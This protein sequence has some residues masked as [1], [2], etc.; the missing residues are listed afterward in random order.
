MD[1]S[2]ISPPS[3]SLTASLSYDP[4]SHTLT[5]VSSGGPVNAVTWTRNGADIS[6]SPYQLRQSLEDG[7]TSTYHNLLT[8]TNGDVEDYIGSFSCTVS[9]SRGISPPQTV[10]VNG[11]FSITITHLSSYNYVTGT[12]I[13][14]NEE[15]HQ[16]NSSVT[17]TCSS[18]LAVQ[19]IQW[20]N[21][22]DNQQVLISN[23]GQQPLLLPIESAT[24][25][26]NNTT[27]TCEVQ[28]LLATGVETVQ[29][30]TTFRVNSNCY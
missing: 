6:S 18:D 29:E 20:L 7:T 26:L 25:N 10:D 28:V 14:G 23:S 27:Y 3:G 12:V 1:E 16:I 19:T 2:F 5:C 22:S 24:L 17:I 9:N 4:T 8:V 13:S 30:M 21:N 15:M 11:M